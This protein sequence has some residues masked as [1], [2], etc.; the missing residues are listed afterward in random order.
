MAPGNGVRGQHNVGLLIP[1]DDR[2]VRLDLILPP[3]LGTP[4]DK[5]KG[6]G[7]L[8]QDDVFV[9]GLRPQSSGPEHRPFICRRCHDILRNPAI[10]RIVPFLSPGSLMTTS[11][12]SPGLTSSGARPSSLWMIP[13]LTP[14]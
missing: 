8:R 3:A 4:Q 5:E 10:S 9:L 2:G 12:S 1:A 7:V 11:T 13:P 6:P 14:L